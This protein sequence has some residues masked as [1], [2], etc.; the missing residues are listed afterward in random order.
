MRSPMWRVAWLELWSP[1]YG[2]W[3][4]QNCAL[5]IKPGEDPA[6]VA[7]MAALDY[8]VGTVVPRSR[9]VMWDT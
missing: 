2:E 3:V 5:T 9:A 1:V 6:E 8:R 7:A 4:R